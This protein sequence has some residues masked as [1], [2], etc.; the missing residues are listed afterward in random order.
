M[1]SL[2]KSNHKKSTYDC[3]CLYSGG[4]DSTYMLFQLVKK[5]KLRVLAVT[6]DNHFLAPETHDNI[7]R[8][9]KLINVDHVFCRPDFNVVKELVTASIN[10]S[11]RIARAKELSFMVGFVCWPCFTM[12][13]LYALKTAFEKNVHNVAI[14]TTPGQLRQKKY[15]LLSKY[16]GALDSY[17]SMSRPML[18][19]LRRI[20]YKNGER[21]FSLTLKEKM[22]ALKTRLVPFYDYI[23]YQEEKAIRLIEKELGWRRPINTDS[24]STNCELNALGILLHIERFNIHPY[25]IPFAHDVREGVLGRDEA[26]RAIKKLPS[27]ENAKVIADK[28]GVKI[29]K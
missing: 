7:K 26:L 5:H 19:L 9:T 18:K 2:L 12:I 4:K 23:P 10:E 8:I 25:V 3:M 14:G 22:Q 6:L 13:G 15:N 1:V 24:C 28:L 20:G 27:F 29:C 11:N 21:I 16:S 17:Y